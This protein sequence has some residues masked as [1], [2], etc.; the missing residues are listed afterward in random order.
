[1]LL[2]VESGRLD[3]RTLVT[4]RLALSQLPE[5]IELL[6]GEACKVLLDPS[7]E[8]AVAGHGRDPSDRKSF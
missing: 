6:D 7:L 8:E 5:A 3:L 2:L 1:M 4:H